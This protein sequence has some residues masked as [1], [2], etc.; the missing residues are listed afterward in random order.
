MFYLLFWFGLSSNRIVV[1]TCECLSLLTNCIVIGFIWFWGFIETVLDLRTNITIHWI[2]H[3]L[4]HLKFATYSILLINLWSKILWFSFRLFYCFV[5]G[6]FPFNSIEILLRSMIHN[7][8]LFLSR[9]WWCSK[10][11]IDIL[12]CID[13]RFKLEPYC[14]N[15]ISIVFKY[16]AERNCKHWT[17]IYL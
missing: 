12:S 16:V 14:Y 7:I 15:Q 10:T 17:K 8:F 6:R 5:C 2:V 9:K 13:F 4:F 3:F 1:H 11:T